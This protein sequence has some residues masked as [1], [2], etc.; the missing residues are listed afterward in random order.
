MTLY[1]MLLQCLSFQH[2]DFGHAVQRPKCLWCPT[3]VR[4]QAMV[5]LFNS[6][7]LKDTRCSLHYENG[8]VEKNV[9]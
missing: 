2:K 4:V 1:E 7:L 5:D 6:R 3:V 8:T 9:L